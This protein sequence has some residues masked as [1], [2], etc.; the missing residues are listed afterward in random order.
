[1]VIDEFCKAVPKTRKGEILIQNDRL[2]FDGEEY[3]ILANAEIKLIHSHKKLE[4][5]IAEIKAK[6]GIA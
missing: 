1:M 3:L 4:K 5:G 6:L 2:Y